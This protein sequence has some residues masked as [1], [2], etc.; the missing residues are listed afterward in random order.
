M[1][2]FRVYHIAFGLAV[3]AAYFT[4]ESLGLIHAWMG[5]GIAALLALRLVL[6]LA[7]KR[8]FEFRRLKPSLATPPRGQTG[9]R[10]PAIARLTML[11]LFITVIGSGVTG[12]VMDKGGTL[13]GQSIRAHDEDR[14]EERRPTVTTPGSKTERRERE[15]KHGLIETVHK[16][17]GSLL[18]PL[19]LIH[20]IYLLLFRF[21]LA[22]FILFFPRK[23]AAA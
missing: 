16:T 9:M 13:V 10:H 1:N 17:L 20:A 19:V 12:I 4:G 6:G 8:G 14:A 3:A 23:R 15:E 18:L 5:Y 11:A 22:R 21:D 7:R 2:Q